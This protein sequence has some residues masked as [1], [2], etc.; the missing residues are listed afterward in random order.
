VTARGEAA[1]HVLAFDR[2][3]AISVATRLPVGLGE[4]GWGDTVLDLPTGQWADLLTGREHAGTAP[5]PV[6][7]S[8]LPVALLVREL[9]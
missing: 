7:L 2:G 9:G 4:R 6:L 3:G 8:D 5:L 1:G